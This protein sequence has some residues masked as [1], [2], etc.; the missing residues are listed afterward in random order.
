[1]NFINIFIYLLFAILFIIIILFIIGLFLPTTREATR[2]TEFKAS[3][4]TIYELVTDNENMLN[5]RKSLKDVKI[6]EKNGE[7]ETWTEYPKSGPSITIRTRKKVPYS[8]YE[9]EFVNNSLFEGY[10]IGT[11]DP[12]ENGGTKVSFTEHINIPNPVFRSISF[13]TFDL[14]SS[15]DQTLTEIA[16]ALGE[17]YSRGSQ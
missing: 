16:G 7:I 14:G 5:W 1:M 8:R 6:H 9:M 12:L 13:L 2:T 3:S 15:I 10:W 4:E 11:F 17:Q